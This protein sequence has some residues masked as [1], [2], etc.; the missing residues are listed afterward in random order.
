MPQKLLKYIKK[1]K[2][3][4]AERPFLK[5]NM[6]LKN[7]SLVLLILINFSSLA[8][9][10]LRIVSISPS[11]TEIIYALKSEKNLVGVTTSCDYP[12]AAKSLPKIG[13][14]ANPNLEK[15]VALKPDLVAGIGNPVSQKN[16]ILQKL[17]IKTKIWASPKTFADIYQIISDLGSILNKK[18]EA[19][20][21]ISEMTKTVNRYK[22]PKKNSNN[23]VIIIIWYQPLIAA[24]DQSFVSKIVEAAGF[25]NILKTK[26]EFPIIGKEFIFQANPDFII[27]TEP[28]L[29]NLLLQDKLFANLKAIRHN[30]VI[31]KINPD[32]LLRP[33]P[34]FVK[35]IKQLRTSL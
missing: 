21:L 18:S 31:Y 2:Y 23:K 12:F 32:W 1:K 15:I 14:F 13:D 11:V 4:A 28:K 6:N 3:L 26:E 10:S 25:E 22:S 20:K 19:Q 35:A 34:R 29:I 8:E 27:L 33:G 16:F 24:G 9:A 17:G 7:I 30:Q 5:K